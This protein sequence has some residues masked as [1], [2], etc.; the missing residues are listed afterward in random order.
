MGPGPGL[1]C[2]SSLAAPS[3]DGGCDRA[4]VALRPVRVFYLSLVTNM[5]PGSGRGGVG[6]GERKGEARRRPGQPC[7]GPVILR[8]AS[9]VASWLAG[10]HRCPGE[11]SQEGSGSKAP[12]D[13]RATRRPYRLQWVPPR[14]DFHPKSLCCDEHCPKKQGKSVLKPLLLSTADPRAPPVP[15]GASWRRAQ[16]GHSKASFV[17]SSKFGDTAT[18]GAGLEAHL[19]VLWHRAPGQSQQAAGCG[20][21]AVG[22]SKQAH[23]EG[24]ALTHPRALPQRLQSPLI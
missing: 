16:K 12:T 22:Q 19:M 1:G 20:H 10:G 3:S 7:T 6:E 18:V 15:P 9:L 4:G 5:V 11:S 14:G 8:A 24:L 23:R 17:L 13:P 2:G 21:T